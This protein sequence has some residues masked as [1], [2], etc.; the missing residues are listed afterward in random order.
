[1]EDLRQQELDLAEEYILAKIFGS[2]ENIRLNTVPN[3]LFTQFSKGKKFEDFINENIQKFEFIA[4]GFMTE[5][6][7][8]DG[9]RVTEMIV[10]KAT[11][12]NG[13]LS[14]P[15]L[16]PIDYAKMLDEIIGF[17]ALGSILR[18]L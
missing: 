13:A 7:Y 2:V 10:N 14:L 3:W 4:K 15:T 18:S 6:G 17:E 9:N 16:K 12:L 11:I 1:M 8:I 5:N